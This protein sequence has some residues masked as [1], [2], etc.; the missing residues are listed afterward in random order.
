MFAQ[1]QNSLLNGDKDFQEHL[2]AR[3]HVRTLLVEN[4][5]H[6]RV[7]KELTVTLFGRQGAVAICSISRV[8][9]GG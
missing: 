5:L 9:Q 8:V 4:M 6:T 1:R 7:L 3:R 2:S